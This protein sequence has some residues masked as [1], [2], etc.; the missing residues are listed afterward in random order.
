MLNLILQYFK[1]KRDKNNKDYEI[2]C[3][4][5]EEYNFCL[6]KNLEFEQIESIHIL[7]ENEEDYEELS[8]TIDIKKYKKLVIFF[9]NKRMKYIDA[10]K[11]ANNNL[12]NKIVIILHSDIFLLSGFEKISIDNFKEKKMYALSR[13]NVYKGKDTD[14]NQNIRIKKINGKD[15]TTTVD[16]WCLKTPIPEN[17][18]K[19]SF[20]QQ[21]VWGSENRLI[22]IFKKN[23]YQV[24]SPKQL[25]MIHWHKT[26]IRPTQNNNWIK[27]DGS[28][29]SNEE[30]QKWRKAN[31]QKAKEICGG[32]VPNLLG[33]AERTDYL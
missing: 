3:K 23:N 1:V 9:L 13:T 26:L 30:H 5:Q 10:L 24:I 17:I 20:Q 15:Y 8:S 2:L 28:L 16:G 25:I 4:R 27:M 21:N 32:D 22:W 11:Y 7:L 31:I 18:V 33:S 19:E 29:V 12:N 6:K 14:S